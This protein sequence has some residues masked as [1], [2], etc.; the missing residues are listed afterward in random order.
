MR[1]LQ[2]RPT[3]SRAPQEGPYEPRC[4]I[5]SLRILVMTVLIAGVLSV[6]CDRLSDLHGAAG[7]LQL[8]AGNPGR[9]VASTAASG[10]IPAASPSDREHV[11]RDCAAPRA[12]VAPPPT[13]LA[14]PE[15]RSRGGELPRQVP[16][17]AM[18]DPRWRQG[19]MLTQ[20]GLFEEA[21]GLFLEVLCAWP[22]YLSKRQVLQFIAINRAQSGDFETAVWSQEK[23]EEFDQSFGSKGKRG[24]DPRSRV[25]IADLYIHAG[26]TERARQ[27]LAEVEAVLKTPEGLR[28]VESTPSFYLSLAIAYAW[29]PDLPASYGALATW[30]AAGIASSTSQPRSSGSRDEQRQ[31]LGLLVNLS[32]AYW[33]AEEYQQAQM[34]SQQV[35]D[36]SLDGAP[37]DSIAAHMR[38]LKVLARL[39]LREGD[40]RSA[41]EFL[42]RR[43]ALQPRWREG[44]RRGLAPNFVYAFVEAVKYLE[45][46]EDRSVWGH[47]YRLSGQPDA[48]TEQFVEAVDIV[49]HLRGFVDPAYRVAFFGSRTGPYASLVGHLVDLRAMPDG[50][51]GVTLGR[52]GQSP[53]EAAFRYAD[54]ARGRLLSERVAQLRLSR[55]RLAPP[56]EV[57]RKELE[58]A[59]QARSELLQGIPYE[60]SQAYRAFDQFVTSLRASHPDYA[61]LKYP[62][63]VN[64]S[65]VPAREGEAI[66]AYSLLED[67]VIAWLLRPN[68]HPRH[69][70]VSVPRERV[71]QAI[72]RLR[73]SLQATEGGLPPFNARASA[74]LYT[75]LLA[76]PLKSLPSE[77]RI[78]VI[79]DAELGSVPFEILGRPSTG[80]GALEFAGQTHTITYSA[81]A[82]VL[83][84]QRRLEVR[85]P[86][87]H[88]TRRLFAVGDP[89]YDS[90]DPR[91][92]QATVDATRTGDYRQ[93]A[94]RSY[95]RGRGLG[96]FKR[97]PWTAQ[98]V[99]VVAAALAES[100][101]SADVLV[102]REATEARVK[103]AE[104]SSYRFLH[105]AT[106]GVLSTEV[107]YLKEPALVLSQVGDLKGEDGLLAMSEVLNLAL[108]ADLTT[109][110]ACQTG[111]GE[112]LSGEGVMG[113]ARA[114]QYAGSRSVLVSLWNVDDE[115]TASLMGSFYRYLFHGV[116]IADALAHAKRDIRSKG[117]RWANPFFWGGFV[118]FTPE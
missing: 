100:G 59:N 82:T 84:H 99:R 34:L 48:A 3:S 106:H 6:A 107:P 1:D 12:G 78:K 96:L 47:A 110:S 16:G 91:E 28:L 108:D 103:A 54:A 17:Q 83:H 43:Q 45:L 61:L 13:R 75:W 105:F 86:A 81:S 65:E 95:S 26:D 69:F 113:L 10:T 101:G 118:L 115:A 9:E 41:L 5:R 74:D 111:L 80:G 4:A 31:P 93:T 20:Q 117:G 25:A 72:H 112:Y 14:V 76:E 68:E 27:R 55:A 66:L 18:M 64:A 56:P 70:V 79:P 90:P 104:L 88:R 15:P 42:E 7:P 33:R 114:F 73:V 11:L 23:V 57:S 94:L 67:R 44:V 97:L 63:P 98:E 109:L 92:G 85:P 51:P 53:A 58:L 35:L 49:E 52:F 62:V 37:V 40:G 29:L 50:L 102:G 8:T 116:S 89:V 2:A 21:Y 19:W 39:K 32:E 36:T 38:A 60:E 71:R 24:A 22:D 46:A 77:T 30:Q 87:K